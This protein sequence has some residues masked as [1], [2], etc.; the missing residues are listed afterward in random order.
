MEA[1]VEVTTRNGQQ[2]ED[3]QKGTSMSSREDT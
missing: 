1:Y 2:G 3:G